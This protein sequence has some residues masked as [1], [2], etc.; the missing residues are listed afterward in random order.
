[1]MFLIG[2]AARLGVPERL[3][4]A[5]AIVGMVIA[6]LALLA[7][8]KGCYDHE[9]IKRHQAKVEAQASK[10]RETAADERATDAATNSASEKD[11]HHAIDTAP[12]GGA[13]SPASRAL[14]CERLRKLGRIPAACGHPG[15]H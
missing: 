11:L 9:V 12:Q 15:G 2:I 10:A 1:M 7:I 13:L 5:V 14:A 8:L 3:Q 4:R 6:A